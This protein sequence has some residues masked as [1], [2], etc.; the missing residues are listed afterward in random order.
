MD[1]KKGMD[2]YIDQT[3]KQIHIYRQIQVLNKQALQTTCPLCVSFLCLET[4][5]YY[6]VLAADLEPTMC[7]K[8]FV[9]FCFFY[10]FLRQGLTHCEVQASLKTHRNPSQ[11][12]EEQDCRYVQV[13]RFNE[14]LKVDVKVSSISC[15][16]INT[17]LP[18]S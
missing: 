7:V 9:V 11:N 12:P 2:R 3:D 8:F 15:L 1:V 6:V 18:V 13:H 5:S 14:L 17:T 4:R 10:L 16:N